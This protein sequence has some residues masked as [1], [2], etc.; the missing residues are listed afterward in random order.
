MVGKKDGM[1]M[2][3]RAGMLGMGEVG[4][5]VERVRGEGGGRVGLAI[6]ASRVVCLGKWKQKEKRDGSDGEKGVGG[7]RRGGTCHNDKPRLKC[8]ND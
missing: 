8:G 2:T 4:M 7:Y 3:S 1:A 5:T 6:V